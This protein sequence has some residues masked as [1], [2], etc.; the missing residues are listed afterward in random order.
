MLTLD[1]AKLSSYVVLLR[2]V[3]IF[4]LR[5]LKEEKENKKL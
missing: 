4:E 2:I 3:W 1:A 5:E